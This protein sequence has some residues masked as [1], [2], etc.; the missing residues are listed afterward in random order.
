MGKTDYLEN[1]LLNHFLRNTPTSAPST[2]WISLHTTPT[3]DAGGGT[4]V[5][6]NGYQRQQAVFG[7]PPA[8][9]TLA[10]TTVIV[11]PT[12]TPSGW[13]TVTHAA[14]W[15][16]QSGGNMLWHTAL[17]QPRTVNPSDSLTFQI[18]QLVVNED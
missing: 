11:F 14:I 12:A 17:V 16:A 7:S 6:G 1:A 4:E 18:G 2:V 3:T 9:G 10:N 8:A 13:G 15:D 5:A